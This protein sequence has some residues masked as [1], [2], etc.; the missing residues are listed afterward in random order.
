MILG[1]KGILT[2]ELLKDKIFKRVIKSV[3]FLTPN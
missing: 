3:S 2:F 1:P